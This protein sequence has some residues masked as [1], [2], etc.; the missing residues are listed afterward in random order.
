MIGSLLLTVCLMGQIPPP[1]ADLALD[2]G[3]Q[4]MELI[5]ITV[6]PKKWQRNGGQG[7]G[8]YWKN[9]RVLVIRQDRDTHEEIETLLRSLRR[10][11]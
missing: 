10:E 6:K 11:Y 9:Q 1:S 8:F 7:T 3:D 5:Q 2:N 4:I